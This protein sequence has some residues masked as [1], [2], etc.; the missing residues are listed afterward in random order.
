M[1]VGLVRHRGS[2]DRE[3]ERLISLN[4][5]TVMTMKVVLTRHAQEEMIERGVTKD[6]VERA[7]TRGSKTRQTE[8]LLAVY[9]YVR[10]AYS[11]R[12]DT[13]VVNTV[14]VEGGS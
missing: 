2:S 1:G 13:Y 5:I 4:V 14:M 7:L 11:V 12:K 6:M 8:G 3:S 10:V 9:A